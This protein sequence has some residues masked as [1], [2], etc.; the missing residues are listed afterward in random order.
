MNIVIALLLCSASALSLF[1]FGTVE[2]WS[3][4]IMQLLI[5]FIALCSLLKGIMSRNYSVY[6]FYGSIVLLLVI[7]IIAIQMI[8]LPVKVVASINPEKNDMVQ[9]VTTAL[10]S[11]DSNLSLSNFWIKE[12]VQSSRNELNTHYAHYVTFSKHRSTLGLLKWISYFL[13]FISVV[14]WLSN[15]RQATGMILYI[16][17]IGFLTALIGFINHYLTPNKILWIRETVSPIF[18]APFYNENNF[19]AFEVMILPIIMGVLF[20]IQRGGKYFKT[21]RESKIPLLAIYSFMTVFIIVGIFFSMSRAGITFSILT[22]LFMMIAV[23]AVE[24]GKIILVISAI[25]VIIVV[26]A[27]IWIG[28]APVKEEILTLK[29]EVKG[30]GSLAPRLIVWQKSL[31]LVNIHAVLGTG[32]STFSLTFQK[33]APLVNG[34]Y[35]RLH[36]DFLQTLIENGPVAFIGVLL[37]LVLYYV[38]IMKSWRS[39]TSQTQKIVVLSLVTSVS[40]MLL[41][42]FADFHLQIGAIA[43]IFTVLA[44]ISYGTA[45]N[46]EHLKAQAR[47]SVLSVIIAL[48]GIGAVAYYSVPLLKYDLARLALQSKPIPDLKDFNEEEMNLYTM[49]PSSPTAY[50][51]PAERKLGSCVKDVDT[52][53]N[54]IKKDSLNLYLFDTK[55]RMKLENHLQSVMKALLN[56]IEL[57]PNNSEYWVRLG[58]TFELM[59]WV[60]DLSISVD[61]EQLTPVPSHKMQELSSAA[62]I[63]YKTAITLDPINVEAYQGLGK[64]YFKNGKLKEAQEVFKNYMIIRP[65][66]TIFYTIITTM[67]ATEK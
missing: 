29:D 59:E 43:F 2:V 4:S 57:E 51:L 37:I 16:M 54:S 60:N 12:A 40:I 63:M 23:H 32:Q 38:K 5:V 7:A 44:A 53:I 35:N 55:W 20:S 26:T 9:K 67:L 47:T 61:I 18:F 42:S 41:M 34:R 50:Y 66:D 15:R 31:N 22:F 3:F 10:L 24:H 21:S 1:F 19:S 39:I 36:N 64:L 49:F 33:Y 8:S 25:M 58:Q 28:F 62:E 52:A 48:T 46:Y 65:Y 45:M 56:A 13:L 30:I 11:I 14:Q 17:I 6:H 27:L